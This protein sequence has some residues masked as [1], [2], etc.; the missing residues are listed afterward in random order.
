[1]KKN[2]LWFHLAPE[3]FRTY[4]WKLHLPFHSVSSVVDFNPLTFNPLTAIRLILAWG[5][6]YHNIHTYDNMITPGNHLFW[7]DVYEIA[8]YRAVVDHILLLLPSKQ[9]YVCGK[10]EQDYLNTNMSSQFD[11]SWHS[12]FSHPEKTCG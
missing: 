8:S 1:M 9:I 7:I 3:R 2:K 4:E 5:F 12:A 6:C 10:S 11:N